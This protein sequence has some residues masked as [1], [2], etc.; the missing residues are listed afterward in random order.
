MRFLL[1]RS[2]A[3]GPAFDEN[4]QGVYVLCKSFSLSRIRLVCE[5]IGIGP[6]GFGGHG[7][8]SESAPHSPLQNS[9]YLC[10]AR[11]SAGI[12]LFDIFEG[13]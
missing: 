10:V 13:T 12:T 8:E 9:H 5:G 3:G 6:A 11:G 7:G 4:G 1:E 2:Q